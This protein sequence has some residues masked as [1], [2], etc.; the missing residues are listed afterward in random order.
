MSAAEPEDRGTLEI[1]HSVVR[2]V[3][4][5]AASR[6][7]GTATARRRLGRG[8]P[9]VRVSGHGDHVDLDLDLALH[10]PASVPAVVDRV[11]EAVAGEVRDLTSYRVRG[12]AVTVSALVRRP[13][14]R[15]E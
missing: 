12:L 5:H 7:P 1:A 10:Y 14:T 6:V 2:K 3:A 8:G 4:E 11:R 9:S 13:G 15:V